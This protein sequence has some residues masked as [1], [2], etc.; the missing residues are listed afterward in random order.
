MKQII[1]ERNVAYALWENIV[2]ALIFLVA[3]FVGTTFFSTGNLA[4]TLSILSGLFIVVCILELHAQ[5]D[6]QKS[7]SQPL[8]KDEKHDPH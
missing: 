7:K 8:F 2:Y 4:L 3:L 1:L 5:F 6:H